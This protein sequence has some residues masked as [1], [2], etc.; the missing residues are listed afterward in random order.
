MG[1]D[2]PNKTL[3]GS[4]GPHNFVPAEFRHQGQRAPIHQATTFPPQ[5]HRRHRSI[6]KQAGEQRQT[7]H[8]GAL[9]IKCGLGDAS[10]RT[11]RMPGHQRTERGGGMDRR[12]MARPS[13]E[14]CCGWLWPWGLILPDWRQA[15]RLAHYFLCIYDDGPHR[16]RPGSRPERSPAIIPRHD[17]MGDRWGTKSTPQARNDQGAR[18]FLV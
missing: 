14:C 8:P 18:P 10:P 7:R 6:G 3:I 4:D 1:A 15:D 5:L 16:Y 13:L 17:K 9:E 2:T 12:G 11:S